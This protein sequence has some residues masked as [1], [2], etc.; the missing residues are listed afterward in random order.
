MCGGQPRGLLAGGPV[1]LGGGPSLH[2][3]MRQ[4]EKV[5]PKAGGCVQV[6]EEQGCATHAGWHQLPWWSTGEAHL[7][8]QLGWAAGVLPSTHCWWT[9]SV[10]AHCCYHC[11]FSLC[12]T[13]SL[14]WHVVVPIPRPLIKW[15]P[16]HTPGSQPLHFY[17]VWWPTLLVKLFSFAFWHS[18]VFIFILS[19]QALLFLPF[20]KYLVFYK[21]L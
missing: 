1:C 17:T 12:L 3:S 21:F 14:T 18:V 13:L 4:K 8:V 11:Y 6:T 10:S 16:A 5:Q 19:L 15:S 2:R 20:P 9:R 7:R